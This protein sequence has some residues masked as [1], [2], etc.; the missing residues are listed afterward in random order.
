MQNIKHPFVYS[1][2]GSAKT[3]QTSFWVRPCSGATELEGA[4]IRQHPTQVARPVVRQGTQ[5]LGHAHSSPAA[6]RACGENSGRHFNP[7]IHS[8][9]VW[10]SLGRP[11]S[12]IGQVPF[13]LTALCPFLSL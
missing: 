5:D 7:E 3:K 12:H 4:L 10:V 11:G 8:S 1:K 9:G 6:A 13:L 2:L